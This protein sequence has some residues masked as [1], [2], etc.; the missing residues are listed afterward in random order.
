MH[1]GVDHAWFIFNLHTK[2]SIVIFYTTTQII[3]N[4]WAEPLVLLEKPTYL[5]DRCLAHSGEF[6]STQVPCLKPTAL[7]LTFQPPPPPTP[8]HPLSP[9]LYYNENINN[10]GLLVL[11]LFCTME[12]KVKSDSALNISKIFSNKVVGARNYT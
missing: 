2:N 11:E 3:N 1:D 12:H 6:P 10:Y 5:E 7:T 8:A 4:I 9:G